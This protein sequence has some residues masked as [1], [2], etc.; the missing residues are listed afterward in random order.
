MIEVSRTRQ[1]DRLAD[2][3]GVR[4][5]TVAQRQIGTGAGNAIVQT[6]TNG[7]LNMNN[8]GD[9]VTVYNPNGEVVLTFDIDPLSNNP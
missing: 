5:N 1:A 7:I 3:R 9:F 2:H 6:A 4:D 8:A